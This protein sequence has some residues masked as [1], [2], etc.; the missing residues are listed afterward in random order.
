MP[1]PRN[2][3]S[4]LAK[5]G[6]AAISGRP[7]PRPSPLPR[8][9]PPRAVSSISPRPR[10]RGSMRRRISIR[11]CIRSWRRRRASIFSITRRPRAIRCTGRWASHGWR[12]PASLYAESDVV[13]TA[14]AHA[15]LIACLAAIT[16]HGDR[17]F[18][19]S[20]NYPTI[21][22]IARH[23]GI[24]LVPIEMDD[25]GM[26]PQ[27]LERAA[28]AGEARLLYI[29]PTLQNPTTS[30][31]SHD[32]R[33]AIADIARRYGMTIIEDDIF[34]LLD[35]RLQPPTLFTP[36]AGPDLSHHQHFED[37]VARPARWFRGDTSGQ[38]RY[39]DPPSNGGQRPRRWPCGRSGP[40][41][42]RGRHRG[43]DPQCHHCRECGAARHW[44]WSCCAGARCIARPSAPYL[45]LKLPE[46]WTPGDFARALDERGV[47]VTPG[48]AFAIDRRS[49]DQGVRICFGGT[50][51]P[52]RIARGAAARQHACSTKTRPSASPRWRERLRL[53]KFTISSF[54]AP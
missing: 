39:P 31:L 46:A 25:G 40:A 42:D 4:C 12:A 44:R 45:W 33:L 47:R 53:S 43:S 16:Q 2:W 22:P 17:M 5:W 6:A 51:D 34:R 11:R 1:K 36:G 14:G 21:K 27:S 41:L 54:S 24:T 10:R 38:G 28:R 7:A 15:G 49:D 30:T 26:V 13:V 37:P 52:R 3:D 32:R 48:T 18:V 9:R 8:Q 23:L 50:V 20:L 29:V 35:P 19:E